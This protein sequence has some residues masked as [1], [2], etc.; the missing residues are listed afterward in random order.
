MAKRP[1]RKLP[2]SRY[3][4]HQIDCS[5]ATRE[6]VAHL[7]ALGQ[8][9]PRLRDV[10]VGIVEERAN[11]SR[12]RYRSFLELVKAFL[13]CLQRV[14]GRRGNEVERTRPLA[15]LHSPYSVAL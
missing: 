1:M 15:C 11:C 8:V 4:T 7:L 12:E 6:F 5:E 9:D 10:I 13:P 3:Q 2:R 14:S